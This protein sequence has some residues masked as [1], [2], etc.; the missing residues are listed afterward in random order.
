MAAVAYLRIIA[1]Y[2]DELDRCFFSYN[3]GLKRRFPFRFSI[4]DYQPHELKD[5]FLKKVNDSKWKFETAIDKELN[6]FFVDNI[7]KFP[8]F[9][10]DM[11]NLLLNCKFT[12]SR[13]VFGK[14]PKNRGKLT[15]DDLTKGLKRFQD[16]KGKNKELEYYRKV[17]YC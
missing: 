14:H 15:Y 17:M 6:E 3:P 5:I 11:D 9:G 12:H 7:E 1:G 2:P 10:G 8:F 13:R 16:N 4:E